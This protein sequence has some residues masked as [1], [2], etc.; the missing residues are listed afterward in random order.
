[1]AFF[2]CKDKPKPQNIVIMTCSIDQ[3]KLAPNGWRLPTYLRCKN[4]FNEYYLYMLVP[5]HATSTPRDINEI[6]HNDDISNSLI[7]IP[8]VSPSIEKFQD[9]SD[10]DPDVPDS[11][12]VRP[13]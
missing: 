8:T 11:S 5:D 10:N 4:G 13:K 1:M 12:V 2:F 7:Q 9:H 3:Y 6:I